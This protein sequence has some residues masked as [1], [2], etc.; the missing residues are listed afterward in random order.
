[1]SNSRRNFL[2]SGAALAAGLTGVTS[3]LKAQAG[4]PQPNLPP[5]APQ[6]PVRQS[7][8]LTPA[9]E[10]QVPKM[11][12]GGVEI[13]RMVLG[14]NPFYGF[15]HYN[16]NFGTIMKEWYTPDRVCDVMHQCQPL[17]YQCLQL[18]PPGSG[19]AGLGAFRGR[20]RQDAPHFPGH[21]RGRRG[22][23]GKDPQAA[24][25]AK[26]GRSGRHRLPERRNG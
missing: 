19:A 7:E 1:M 3:A 16:N 18:R 24:G 5:G 23:A 2:H 10:I 21:R 20:G 9:S 25:D 17:R 12:F 13:S 11:K 15:A 22:N 6:A 14:V 26:A 4:R 8:P